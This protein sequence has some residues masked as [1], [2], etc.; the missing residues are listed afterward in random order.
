MSNISKRGYRWTLITSNTS[1]L[2]IGITVMWLAYQLGVE[3]NTYL[4]N[5]VICLLGVVMGW[6]V[7]FISSPSSPNESEQFSGLTKAISAFLSGYII[8]KLDR[9]IETLLESNKIFQELFLMR[10]ALFLT[11]FVCALIIVF[12]NRK[13]FLNVVENGKLD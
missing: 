5:W 4:F 6:G 1:A 10:T 8:S 11:A 9:V 3:D 7:G 12:I 13:Y 2:L